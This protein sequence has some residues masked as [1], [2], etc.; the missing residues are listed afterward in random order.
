MEPKKEYLATF[1]WKSITLKFDL[2]GRMT[3]TFIKLKPLARA[4]RQIASPLHVSRTAVSTLARILEATALSLIKKGARAA[5]HSKR[6]TILDR[7][8]KYAARNGTHDSCSRNGK[9]VRNGNH[10]DVRKR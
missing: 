6:K 2:V 10:R 4:S 5:A 3:K 7:D 1:L 8:I 9:L